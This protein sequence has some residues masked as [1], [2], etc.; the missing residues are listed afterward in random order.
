MAR[1]EISTPGGRVLTSG[2]QVAGGRFQL[3]GRELEANLFILDMPDFEVILGISWMKRHK[4]HLDTE[5]NRVDLRGAD[6]VEFIYDRD[7][8]QIRDL[9]V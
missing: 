6:D 1:Y 9:P 5:V 8:F 3:R 4:A 2:T 7:L